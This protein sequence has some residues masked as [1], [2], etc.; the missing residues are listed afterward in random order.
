MALPEGGDMSI[1]G[2]VYPA[3]IVVNQAEV[4]LVADKTDNANAETIKSDQLRVTAAQQVE[5]A[6]AKT[7]S[8]NFVA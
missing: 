8:V 2:P 5:A 7:S 3:Q 1:I 6:D 4:R